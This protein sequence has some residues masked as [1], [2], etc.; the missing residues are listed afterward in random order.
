MKTL[1]NLVG[2][3]LL[4]MS[5][6]VSF[7]QKM[8]EYGAF[9]KSALSPEGQ[10]IVDLSTSIQPT[11][12]LERGAE[13][14]TGMGSPTF[15]M[16]DAPSTSSLSKVL[17]KFS[18]IELIEVRIKEPSDLNSLVLNSEL[19]KSGTNLKAIIVRAEYPVSETEFKN[20]FKSI[21]NTTL[22]LL[23]EVSIPH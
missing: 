10:R 9:L 3:M 8:T 17:S 16:C 5:V 18:T 12:Y 15:V 6:S 19:I 4:T 1:K 23:Y 14:V 20:M 13:K 22:M 7:S 2:I 11:I 21:Q